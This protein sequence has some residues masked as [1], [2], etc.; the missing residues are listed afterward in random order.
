MLFLPLIFFEL[1]I[2]NFKI[3]MSDR[4]RSEF[5]QNITTDLNIL[6][7]KMI[8]NSSEGSMKFYTGYLSIH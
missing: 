5:E 1:N 8:T 4:E 2:E 3:K 6:A 7:N